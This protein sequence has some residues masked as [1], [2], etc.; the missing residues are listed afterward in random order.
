MAIDPTLP[1]HPVLACATVIGDVLDAVA[2]VDPMYM[3][4]HQKAQ[5]LRELSV[6]G[7]RLRGLTLRV[8]AGADDVALDHGARSA[9]AW[10]AHETRSDI[11][12][13]LGAGRLAEALDGRW[14]QVRDGLC[15]GRVTEPQAHVIVHALDELPTDLD[16]GLKEKA[17]A[18][19]VTEA[20]H[21]DPRRLRILGRKVLE[22]IAPDLAARHEQAVLEREEALAAR[23]TS[24][25]FRR[26]GDGTTDVHARLSDAVAA[27][28]RTYLEAYTAPRRSHL[29]DTIAR[30][31]PATGRVLPQ[32]V[33]FGHAFGAMLEAI[34]TDE[35]PVH[36]G[37]ATQV[38]VTIDHDTLRTQLGTAGLDTGDLVS[39]AQAMRLT[40]TARILPVVL[41]SQGQP[42]F[43]GRAKRL[44]TPGQRIAMGIRDKSPWASGTRSAEPTA[45]R[46]PQRG[47]RPTT[48]TSG[49]TAGRPTST[50]ASC[51]APGTTTAPT[52]RRTQPN[53][54]PTATSATTDADRPC[55]HFWGFEVRR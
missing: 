20:A 13:A 6:A 38:V 43:L 31:D 46:S 52:T 8:L 10:L 1:A 25:T 48:S 24:L 28:L 12:P 50:T 17:E 3:T 16:P 54:C 36:G 34:P 45:A 44:F 53:A 32:S 18:H 4:S 5:A 2:D 51:S 9:A 41:D 29:E 47:P 55:L 37:T 21:F 33:L 49:P 11:G 42:L 15:E 7:E 23:Q 35:L 30:T 19:L 26:R 40:C 22:V 14:T 39:V 27:R